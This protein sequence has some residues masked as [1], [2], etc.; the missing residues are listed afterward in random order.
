MG[1]VGVD[2]WAAVVTIRHTPVMYIL[3]VYSLL[4]ISGYSDRGFDR[5]AHRPPVR[6][7][8]VQLPRGKFPPVKD[9]SQPSNPVSRHS[10]SKQ[11][12]SKKNSPP[13]K[14]KSSPRPRARISLPLLPLF[15]P[16]KRV[17]NGVRH[18]GKPQPRPHRSPGPVSSPQPPQP[19]FLHLQAEQI[20]GWETFHLHEFIPRS[21][22]VIHYVDS[23]H[24]HAKDR[25]QERVSLSDEKD[26]EEKEEEDVEEE[27][28]TDGDTSE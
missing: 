22:E 19:S 13:S 25:A 17:V 9:V 15:S 5:G 21:P 28:G 11:H 14:T 8:Q 23:P 3:I 20:P 12:P 27:R 1:T 24:I 6:Q 4:P 10:S 26:E 18:R 2:M 7:V 16:L